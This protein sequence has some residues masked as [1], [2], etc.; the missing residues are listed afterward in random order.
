VAERQAVV[1]LRLSGV[2][3]APVPTELLTAVPRVVVATEANLPTS[4]VCYWTGRTWRLVVEANEPIEQQRLTVMHEFKHVIDHPRRDLLYATHDLSEQV[5]DHFALC[6]LIPRRLVTRAWCGGQQD[7]EA[8]A[9]T[10]VV[11]RTAIERRLQGLG[12][13]ESIPEPQAPA[14]PLNGDNV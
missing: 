9:S 7:T 6:T 12:H 1:L 5:A 3:S 11:P 13:L 2:A 4:G 8:L 14:P 10:F